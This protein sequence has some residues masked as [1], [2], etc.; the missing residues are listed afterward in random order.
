MSLKEPGV[1]L[2]R[3]GPQARPL[4]DPGP[5]V[6]AEQD[7]STVGVRPLCFA[8]R[9]I[10]RDASPERGGDCVVQRMKGLKMEATFV[11]ARSASPFAIASTSSWW[12]RCAASSSSL[13]SS[14][15]WA[16]KTSSM[17]EYSLT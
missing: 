14:R 4:F 15:M 7:L 8:L 17:L 11:A 1:E 12:W 5:R 6:V 9:G 10:V 16:A 13:F 3:L 2:D